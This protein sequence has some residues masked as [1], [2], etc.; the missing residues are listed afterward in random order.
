MIQSQI[1]KPVYQ[2]LFYFNGYD[3]QNDGNANQEQPPTRLMY[4]STERTHK[5][6]KVRVISDSWDNSYLENIHLQMGNG[7]DDEL[8]LYRENIEMLNDILC[9]PNNWNENGAKEFN[10]EIVSEMRKIIDLLPLQPEIFPT[11]RS[12]IQFEYEKDDGS[13]LEFE[14]FEDG[15]LKLFVTNLNSISESNSTRY[16][17]ID[18]AIEVVCDFYR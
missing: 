14:L 12:S 13:Y 7:K 4:N 5:P 3:I 15:R 2:P 8:A 17:D 6:I 10:N 9:L 18:E 16:V 1:H 11:A